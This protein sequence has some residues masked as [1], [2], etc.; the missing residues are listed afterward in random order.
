[1][2][3]FPQRSSNVG[4]Y[5]ANTKMDSSLLYLTDWRERPHGF[6]LPPICSMASHGRYATGS[7]ADDLPECA[8]TPVG[9]S[10]ICAQ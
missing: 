4:T 1:M 5:V 6:V 2:V 10:A 3:R 7:V 8:T 9:V